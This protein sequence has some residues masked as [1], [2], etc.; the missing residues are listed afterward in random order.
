MDHKLT[1]SWWALAGSLNAF[2]GEYNVGPATMNAVMHGKR[3]VV[4][5]AVAITDLAMETV[6][7]ASYFRTSPLERLYRD[8]RAGKFHPLT[9]ENT[10]LY[11]GR[12]ALDQP[13][14]TE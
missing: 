5:E 4:E 11:A 1:V 10:L 9:P 7:G 12:V 3:S 6:G 13:I 14:D 8:A 2:D